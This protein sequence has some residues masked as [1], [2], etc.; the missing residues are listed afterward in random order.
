MLNFFILWGI[1][2]V[3][4]I[5][6][7]CMDNVCWIPDSPEWK[8][9]KKNFFIINFLGREYGF[10]KNKEGINYTWKN[11]ILE[12]IKHP[13]DII[14]GTISSLILTIILFLIK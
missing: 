14:P 4:I 11:R 2:Y 5:W 8:S 3:L 13:R 10:P 6:A 7:M 9:I 1:C 12:V